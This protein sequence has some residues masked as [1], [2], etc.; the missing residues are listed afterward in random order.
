MYLAQGP[1]ADVVWKGQCHAAMGIAPAGTLLPSRSPQCKAPVLQ[2]DL[3]F[4]SVS[5]PGS[6]PDLLSSA[7]EVTIV[8]HQGPKIRMEGR[9]H[10]CLG[11]SGILWWMHISAAVISSHDG[12]RT[13]W[14]ERMLSD[15][16]HRC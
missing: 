3:G 6:S 2:V 9:H 15:C 16:L 11:G 14:F 4:V 10:S 12:I 1:A 5:V 13:A 8:V 7:P